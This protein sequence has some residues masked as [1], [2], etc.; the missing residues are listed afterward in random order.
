M[1]AGEAGDRQ[2][3][4]GEAAISGD[5]NNSMEART[6]GAGELTRGWSTK[7][8]EP[9]VTPKPR[10]KEAR[11]GEL[12]I[13]ALWWR[14]RKERRESGVS[15]IQPIQKQLLMSDYCMPIAVPGPE[16]F[17][18]R[19]KLELHIQLRDDQIHTLKLLLGKTILQWVMRYR[20]LPQLTQALSLP[21]LIESTQQPCKVG[22]LVPVLEMRLLR[23]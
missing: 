5:S 16:G 20:H 3:P 18:G 10:I 6:S 22:T 9:G 23:F 21:Y 12:L 15:F 8:G 19:T 2:G 1:Q 11:P 17:K 13:A 4:R 7:K 14:Q